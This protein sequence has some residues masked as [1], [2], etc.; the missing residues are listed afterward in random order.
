VTVS[1]G[2]STVN[3]QHIDFEQS[4]KD[5]DLAMYQAKEN[6]RNR[7]EVYGDNIVN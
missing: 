4:I 1:I 5:A 7:I 6:G 2:I 3:A